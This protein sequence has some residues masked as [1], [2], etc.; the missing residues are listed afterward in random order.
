MPR[1]ASARPRGGDEG[2]RADDS[3]RLALLDHGAAL[4]GEVIPP[5]AAPAKPYYPSPAEMEELFGEVNA[6]YAKL[7]RTTVEEAAEVGQAL[8]KVKERFAHGSWLIWLERHTPIKRRTAA[9]YMLL[10]QAKAELPARKWATV[11]N[12]GVGAALADLSR[13][14][15]KEKGEVPARV[16]APRP[17]RDRNPLDGPAAKEFTPRPC[18]PPATAPTKPRSRCASC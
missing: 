14:R 13:R 8:I 2:T 3:R 10:A 4:D 12:L 5:E 11:A 16:P 6:A 1:A 18:P 7:L 9:N 15:E 17:E